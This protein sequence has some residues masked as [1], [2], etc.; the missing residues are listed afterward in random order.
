LL[1]FFA[2]DDDDKDKNTDLEREAHF[3]AVCHKTSEEGVLVCPK[4]GDFFCCPVTLG[5]GHTYCRDC[6]VTHFDMFTSA[7]Q[8]PRRGCNA[9][10]EVPTAKLAP[11]GA[12]MLLLHMRGMLRH[13]PN[14]ED[15]LMEAYTNF[16][17]DDRSVYDLDQ[18]IR[19]LINQRTEISTQCRYNKRGR[20]A[21]GVQEE[22]D[23]TRRLAVLENDR[24]RADARRF[25]GVG[26]CDGPKIDSYNLFLVDD[27]PWYEMDA[28]YTKKVKVQNLPLYGMAAEG[29]VVLV[30]APSTHVRAAMEMLDVWGFP[31]QCIVC[32]LDIVE[33]ENV[34][35]QAKNYGSA[36]V[37]YYLAGGIGSPACLRTLKQTG[38]VRVVTAHLSVEKPVEFYQ[39]L[40]GMFR[41]DY[42]LELFAQTVRAGWHRALPDFLSTL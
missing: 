21:L 15:M 25:F 6:L 22:G 11:N 28:Q 41:C 32:H 16:N 9:R 7:R 39:Q 8:C 36:A 14:T 17:V 29:A 4:C 12:L 40:Q 18:L 5:C 2:H 10:V 37:Q 24:I 23:Y 34:K 19:W 35:K 26:T 42:R 31:F 33:V 38:R 27:L 3:R 30:G 13:S 1:A 20:P